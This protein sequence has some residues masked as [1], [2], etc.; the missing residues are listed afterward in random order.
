MKSGT[1]G[2]VSCA[3][4]FTLQN[5]F[6]SKKIWLGPSLEGR[7]NVQFKKAFL[8]DKEV[9]S[10]LYPALNDTFH[11]N[12]C[13]NMSKAARQAL[14]KREHSILGKIIAIKFVTKSFKKMKGQ[15]LCISTWSRAGLVSNF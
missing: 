8:Q 11:R 6:C 13:E 9:L 14:V 1:L 15:C 7:L 12:C 5:C 2:H 3:P 10:V 4:T